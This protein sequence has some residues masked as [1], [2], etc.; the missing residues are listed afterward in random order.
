MGAYVFDTAVL[1]EALCKDAAD[2]D[3]GHSIGGDI[4]PRLVRDGA[5]HVCDLL[6]NKVPGADARGQGAFGSIA[7]ATAVGG[8]W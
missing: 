7:V 6:Q 1:A 5:A 8:G 4:I 3:S 2:E